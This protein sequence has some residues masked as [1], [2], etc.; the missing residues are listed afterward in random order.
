MRPSRKRPLV[1]NA[2]SGPAIGFFLTMAIMLLSGCISI[3]AWLSDRVSEEGAHMTAVSRFGP[4]LLVRNASILPGTRRHGDPPMV[5]VTCSAGTI[6]LIL[7]GQ[8]RDGINAGVCDML[9][10]AVSHGALL[11]GVQV[12]PV[13]AYIRLA[14]ENTHVFD[15][16]RSLTSGG[17]PRLRLVL[18]TLETPTATTANAI[19]VVAH[20]AYHLFAAL[21]R[22]RP[23]V[24]RNEDVGHL[25]GACAVLMILGELHRPEAS[26][27]AAT[28]GLPGP[29]LKSHDAGV[30]LRERL[31]PLFDSEGMV[32][33]GS[34]S[35]DRLISMCDSIPSLLELR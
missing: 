3:P 23:E 24:V 8:H 35:A 19:D 34:G 26:D 9:A 21:N 27:G 33:I 10:S 12:R 16:A 25:V 11:Q 1:G 28:A 7:A 17:P 2:S 6:R 22:R 20:E 14:P 18:P 31:A 30:L 29:V 32:R 15:R 13:V 4:V 5:S